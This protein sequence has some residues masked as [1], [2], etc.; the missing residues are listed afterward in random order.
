MK[1]NFFMKT[2]YWIL[3]AFFALQI[4]FG[5]L[6]EAQIAGP[7]TICPNVDVLYTWSGNIGPDCSF[8]RWDASNGNV[9]YNAFGS[10]T[11]TTVYSNDIGPSS[12][13]LSH[14]VNCTVG[15]TVTSSVATKTI[16]VNGVGDVGLTSSLTSIACSA[17]PQTFTVTASS[18]NA[19]FYVWTVSGGGSIVN[20]TNGNVVT[21]AKPAS[22][23][24][25]ITVIGRAKRS[26][27]SSYLGR[28][29]SITIPV[30]AAMPSVIAGPDAL[31]GNTS[32]VFSVAA[33]PNT[34]WTYNW[35]FSPATSGMTISNPNVANPT[36]SA[37]A[38]IAGGVRTLKCTI[39]AC[40]Q[41][42]TLT[43]NLNVCPS[44]EAPSDIF[45][46]RQG[47][48]CYW[49]FTATSTCA[50]FYQFQINNGS[51]LSL[52][53]SST[54]LLTMPGSYTVKARIVNGCGTSAWRT[55]SFTLSPFPSPCMWKTAGDLA[56][57]EEVEG[58]LVPDV[59]F[60]IMP[61]PAK[62]LANLQVS[63]SESLVGGT[64][65]VFNIAGARMLQTEVQETQFGFA[66]G[67]LERGLYYCRITKGQELIV[68]KLVITE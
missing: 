23:S 57:A 22:C 67:Q 47:G 45:A 17:S 64:F 33:G 27:C 44:I 50:Q 53:S 21:I 56:V 52:T 41:S 34:C 51:I 35:F 9:F 1:S 30:T 43:H 65:E 11:S 20:P 59:D 15:N 19:N 28:A 13:V 37:V 7:S 26:E 14:T 49:K 68:R 10:S 38:G 46:S 8:Y 29:T 61:N 2:K 40:G 16:S 18:V 66:T 62:G 55:E 5:G 4:T 6:A 36:I 48:T 58:V 3:S 63:C 60:A 31:C 54:A 42:V 24:G 39:T 32:A 12:F 25:P